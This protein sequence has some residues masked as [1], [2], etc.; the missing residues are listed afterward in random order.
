VHSGS[1]KH[2][3]ATEPSAIAASS[4]PDHAE[5]VGLTMIVLEIQIYQP[6]AKT[7]DLVDSLPFFGR[8]SFA[9]K[10]LYDTRISLLT[11]NRFLCP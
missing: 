10:L 8:K 3:I 1:I 5:R 6:M 9:K 2:N 11:P 7:A 4:R